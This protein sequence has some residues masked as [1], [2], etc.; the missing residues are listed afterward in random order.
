M[1][2]TRRKMDVR[3]VLAKHQEAF[4]SLENSGRIQDEA[5]KQH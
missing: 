3:S 4:N 5:S 1:E 2:R